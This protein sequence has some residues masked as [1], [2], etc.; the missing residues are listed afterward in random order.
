[1]GDSMLLVDRSFIASELHGRED[2]VFEGQSY[3]PVS[4]HI[5]FAN[6]N[7]TRWVSLGSHRGRERLFLDQNSDFLLFL[8]NEIST[9]CRDKTI[10]EILAYINTTLDAITSPPGQDRD[11]I[12]GKLDI[13]LERYLASCSRDVH[14][15]INVHIDTL[16]LNRILVCRHKGLLAATILGSL[17]KQGILPPGRAHQYRSNLVRNGKVHGAHTWSVYQEHGSK[18]VWICDPRWLTAAQ[19]N[20]P[21][22]IQG[23]GE[24]T[25]DYMMTRLCEDHAHLSMPNE[26]PNELLQGMFFDAM[27]APNEAPFPQPITQDMFFSVPPKT[28]DEEDKQATPLI[29]AAKTSDLK[30]VRY[31]C[32]NKHA[33]NVRRTAQDSFGKTAFHY[34]AKQKES[35]PEII[36]LLQAASWTTDPATIQDQKGDTPLH[37]LALTGHDEALALID[38]TFSKPGWFSGTTSGLYT[39][40][41]NAAFYQNA[42]GMT[43]IMVALAHHPENWPLISKLL[44]AM[45]ATEKDIHVYMELAAAI[46]HKDKAAC[47][48]IQT[49]HP[50]LIG[51]NWQMR[52]TLALKV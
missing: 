19:S 8:V 23:Y 44:T 31:L 14:G 43:P 9:G 41:Y 38:S 7:N 34:L 49:E 32:E 20:D 10:P 28:T 22:V 1:M 51:W 45:Y 11:A 27:P 3:T 26:I 21:T 46:I 42:D 29:I 39:M 50:K 47:E 48:K 25:I 2:I 37:I 35:G 13:Q 18:D 30:Q 40:L 4:H 12:E 17:I 5:N 16:A 24:E 52:N 33:F 6:T 36:T 15:M